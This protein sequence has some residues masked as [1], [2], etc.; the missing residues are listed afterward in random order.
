[1]QLLNTFLIGITAGSIYSLMAIAFVLV[2]RSTR[3]INFA[4]AGMALLSTYF[5]YEAVT[6]IGSF[7]LALPIAMLGGAIFAALVEIILMRLLVKH[8][9]S[10]PIAAVAPIIATLGLLGLI[11]SLIAM[12]WGGQDLRILPPVSNTG[13]TVNGE[14]LVFSPLKLLILITTLVLMALLTIL[15]QRTNLG[16]SLRASAYAPEIARLSGIRVDLIRTLG[17]ALAGAAGAVAGI[18]QT[19]NG[20]GNF[21]PDSIEF[22][23]LLVSGFI[24]AVIGGLDSLLGAVIGGMFLGLTISFVLM[25][26]SGGLFFIAPFVILLAILFVRPQGIIGARAGRRA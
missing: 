17:W 7:W 12:N 16:L 6:R 24:A 26:I 1:M 10:G 25:Y 5:G 8:S 4:Q 19:V 18:F 2:W 9:S 13:F 3:V 23:L 21:S 20:N 14:T 22:S 11:R 15:F